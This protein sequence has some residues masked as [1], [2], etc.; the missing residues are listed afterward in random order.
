VPNFDLKYTRQ[1][2][3]IDVGYLRSVSHSPNCF[4]VESS[5]DELAAAV[6]KDPLQF[7]WSCWPGSRAHAGAATDRERSK[8]GNPSRDATRESPS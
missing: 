1:E 6:S 5:I 3:G 4:A 2:I 7:R 8:W